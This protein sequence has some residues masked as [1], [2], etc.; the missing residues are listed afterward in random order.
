MT[1]II[2]GRFPA[3]LDSVIT[4]AVEALDG[5]FNRFLTHPV[6]HGEFHNRV[7]FASNIARIALSQERAVDGKKHSLQVCAPE[8]FTGH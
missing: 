1:C 2:L 7:P 8:V 4:E 5:S 3:D 6:V